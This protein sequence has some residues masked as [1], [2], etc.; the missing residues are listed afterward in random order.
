MESQETTSPLNSFARATA[1]A[2]LPE[3]VGPAIHIMLFMGHN[4]LSGV[5]SRELSQLFSTVRAVFGNTPDIKPAA[6]MGTLIVFIMIDAGRFSKCYYKHKNIFEIDYEK[7]KGSHTKEWIE[8]TF[9]EEVKNKINKKNA[10]EILKP[11]ILN[12]AKSKNLE[13]YLEKELFSK[14]KK[15]EKLILIFD[16]DGKQFIYKDDE[17]NEFLKKEYTSKLIDSSFKNQLNENDKK[18]IHQYELGEILQ[19]YITKE[20][21]KEIEKKFKPIKLEQFKPIPN[22]SYVKNYEQTKNINS[23][24]NLMELTLE[25]WIFVTYQKL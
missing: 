21:V 19:S 12:K 7:L 1:S 18:I 22:K 20:I 2:V 6:A 17:F 10:K 23:A 16:S 4:L 11:L 13:N 8:L 14:I 3:A 9:G 15:G 5:D 25:G 24:I